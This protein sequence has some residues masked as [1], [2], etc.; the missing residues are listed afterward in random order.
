MN[1]NNMQLLG[2]KR[3][4][5]TK[6]VELEHNKRM[7]E[8]GFEE[9]KVKAETKQKLEIIKANKEQNVKLI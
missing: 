9:D 6:I 1:D 8:I 5:L 4:N 2:L 7:E 3:T